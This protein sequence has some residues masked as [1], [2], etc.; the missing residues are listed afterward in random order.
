MLKHR[1][2]VWGCKDLE[3]DD[4]FPL[5][6][7]QALV[8]LKPIVLVC[9]TGFQALQE[10]W[11]FQ[12]HEFPRVWSVADVFS[13]KQGGVWFVAGVFPLPGVGMRS[14]LENVG[15]SF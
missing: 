2:N 1:F 11:W 7:S 8:F 4:V 15:A 13:S 6:N 10:C 12:A 14:L 5:A 3:Q 9:A